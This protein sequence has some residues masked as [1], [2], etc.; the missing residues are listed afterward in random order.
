[1]R[2][3]FSFYSVFYVHILPVSALAVLPDLHRIDGFSELVS[4]LQSLKS[5]RPPSTGTYSY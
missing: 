5:F 2:P 1:M 4:V 3:C